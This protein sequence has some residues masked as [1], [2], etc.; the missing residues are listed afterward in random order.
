M[1][2]AWGTGEVLVGRPE[3]RIPFKRPR[4]RC[5]ENIRMDLQEVRWGGMDWIAVCQDRYRDWALV[6]AVMDHSFT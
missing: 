2:H 5:E 4:R 1:W 6:R 3:R